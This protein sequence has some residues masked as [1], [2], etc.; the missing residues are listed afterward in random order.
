MTTKTITEEKVKTIY[1][2]SDGKEFDSELR[3]KRYEREIN[4]SQLGN[5]IL[6]LTIMREWYGDLY[7]LSYNTNFDD[8][9]CNW[10]KLN[11]AD[12]FD[13]IAR[14]YSMFDSFFGNPRFDKP[15]SYPCIVCVAESREDKYRWAFATTLDNIIQDTKQFFKKFGYTCDIN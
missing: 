5:D 1:V 9:Y 4:L 2:A 14:Y 15:T 8:A 12:D 3:C 6:H 13:M 10:Y 7:P 11:N